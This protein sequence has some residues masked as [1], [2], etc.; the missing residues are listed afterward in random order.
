MAKI[1]SLK[2]IFWAGI[3]QGNHTLIVRERYL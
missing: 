3:R 1:N 2:S